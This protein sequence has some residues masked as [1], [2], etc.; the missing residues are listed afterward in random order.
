MHPTAFVIRVDSKVARRLSPVRNAWQ[1]L[2][3][4]VSAEISGDS[5]AE[6]RSF[7]MSPVWSTSVR[8]DW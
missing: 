8:G 4:L 1:L 2:F 3:S 5:G 7:A 6:E